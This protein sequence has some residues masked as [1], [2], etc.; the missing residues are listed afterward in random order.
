MDS[1]I[2]II[3]IVAF[4][5]GVAGSESGHRF[6]KVERSRYA[7]LSVHFC[8]GFGGALFAFV[9]LSKVPGFQFPLAIILGALYG[10]LMANSKVYNA[11]K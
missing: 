4:I 10:F 11:I 7:R 6:R 9:I 3:F 5:A 1:Q 8:S 2:T